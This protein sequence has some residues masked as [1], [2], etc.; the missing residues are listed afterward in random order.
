MSNLAFAIFAHLVSASMATIDFNLV[1]GAEL[2][3]APFAILHHR[4]FVHV[5]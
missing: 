3:V 5:D 4:V 1:R 2:L